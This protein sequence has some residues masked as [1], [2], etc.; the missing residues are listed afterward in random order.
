[1]IVKVVLRKKR[2]KIKEKRRV[3]QEKSVPTKETPSTAVLSST[4][5]ELPNIEVKQND[6]NTIFVDDFENISDI[7]DTD[8]GYQRLTDYLCDEAEDIKAL[9]VLKLRLI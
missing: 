4:T 5:E 1:A 2:K 7:T 9:G 3:K 8:T 6:N